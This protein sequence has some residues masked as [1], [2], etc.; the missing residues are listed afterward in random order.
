MTLLISDSVLE[1]QS[2]ISD[3]ISLLEKLGFVIHP[4]KEM[5]QKLEKFPGSL[6]IGF[7]VF[8]LLILVNFSIETWNEN[9]L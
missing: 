2:N 5:S 9:K 6:D 3:T 1:C 8:R 7:L 4:K